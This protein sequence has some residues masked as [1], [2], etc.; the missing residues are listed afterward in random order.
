VGKLTDNIKTQL[1]EAMKAKD[2]TRLSTL[3]MLSSALNYEKIAKL[4]ELGDE[5]EVNVVRSEAKK[6]KDAIEAYE[7]AGAKDRAEKE[8]SELKILQEFMPAEMGDEEL[9]KIVLETITEMGA[10][11]KSEMGKVIGAVRAKTKGN[12]DGK[13]IADLVLQNLK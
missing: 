7:K 12:A 3:K 10:K 5:E 4:H 9:K 11:D 1:L 6:R 13:K 8:S 2:E